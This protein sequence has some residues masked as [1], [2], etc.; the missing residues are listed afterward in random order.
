MKT[1][2]WFDYESKNIKFARQNRNFLTKSEWLFWHCVLKKKWLKYRFLR[3]K[4]IGNY[5]VDFYCSTLLLAIEIDWESHESTR[6]YDKKRDL[7]LASLWIK[8]IRYRDDD[9]LKN[10]EWV[11]MDLEN[12][13]IIR[14]KELEI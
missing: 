12:R 8:T 1:W 3:Q 7:Y 4:P 9:V 11:V 6:D 14:E 5:I 10:M 2:K 13:I